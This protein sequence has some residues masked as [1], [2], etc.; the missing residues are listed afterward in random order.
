MV[1]SS[2]RFQTNCASGGFFHSPKVFYV[3]NTPQKFPSVGSESVITRVTCAHFGSTKVVSHSQSLNAS[4]SRNSVLRSTGRGTAKRLRFK[5]EIES[6]GGGSRPNLTQTLSLHL[7]RRAR[8]QCRTS[9]CPRASVRRTVQ[10]FCLLPSS[11]SPR[12]HFEQS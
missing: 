7:A 8:E 4:R 12:P 1:S 9:A 6:R 11:H 3:K 2:D 10:S 5:I